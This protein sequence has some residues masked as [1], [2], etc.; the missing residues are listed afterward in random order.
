[1]NVTAIEALGASTT[2]LN[3]TLPSELKGSLKTFTVVLKWTEV[4]YIIA[5]IT[6]VLE[7]FVGLLGFCSR[8]GSCITYIISGLS[9][10]S[11]IAASIMATALASITVGAIKTASKSYGVTASINTSFLAT[12]WLAVAFS[13]GASLFWMFTV[14]C[15]A[16]NKNSKSRGGNDNEKLIPAGAYA[17]VEDT[18]YQGQQTGV[19][20]NQAF[21]VPTPNMK[22]T[23]HNG[24]YEPYSHGAV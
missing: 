8:A 22:P 1:M 14:C 2:G 21:A 10:L 13:I 7:L 16:S 3:V 18:Q 20:N 4:V 15:C 12:T 17:R 19:Y 24:A 6:C 5:V 11:I 9:T 23:H